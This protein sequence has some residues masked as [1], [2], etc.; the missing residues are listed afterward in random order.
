MD[1]RIDEPENDN[2]TP[3]D[4]SLTFIH[5]YF[6]CSIFELTKLFSKHIAEISKEEMEKTN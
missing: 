4:N 6:S 2:L 5:I 3:H 1:L